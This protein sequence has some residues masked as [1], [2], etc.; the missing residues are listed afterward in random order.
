MSNKNLL[1]QLYDRLLSASSTKPYGL[2]VFKA[3]PAPKDANKYEAY[4]ATLQAN[5]WDI[6]AAIAPY[7]QDE[8][9][10]VVSFYDPIQKE[11]KFCPML[12]FFRLNG[13]H[14]S[15]VNEGLE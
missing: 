6:N 9:I 7:A 1:G 13:I 3:F 8:Q 12:T 15:V 4:I 14:V 11:Y 2:P 10:E 5:S